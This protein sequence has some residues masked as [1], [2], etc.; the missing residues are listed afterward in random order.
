MVRGLDFFSKCAIAERGIGDEIEADVALELLL[1][2]EG[3]EEGW[4]V[5]AERPLAPLI[6]RAEIVDFDEEANPPDALEDT[7]EAPTDAD[8]ADRCAPDIPLVEET[9]NVLTEVV[10]LLAA[11][12]PEVDAGFALLCCEEFCR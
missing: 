6:E 3:A 12:R 4:E 1:L 8:A 2:P 10:A 11:V 7:A 9:E 5:V